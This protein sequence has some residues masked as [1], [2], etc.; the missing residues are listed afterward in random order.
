MNKEIKKWIGQIENEV[1]SWSKITMGENTFGGIDFL[2]DKKEIGHI[3]WNGDMDI[4]FGKKLTAEF[5]EHNFV[6]E[7]KYVPNRAITYPVL[8]EENVPF[9]ISLLRF[10][11]LLKIK[12]E[13]GNNSQLKNNIKTE[14]S[15]ASFYP[16][17][18]HLI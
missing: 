16:L 7:H 17:V 11:Y 6:E 1:L 10:S 4:L 3:H 2:F 15:K 13:S 8:S 14:L 12:K 18:K 9:A 5:L